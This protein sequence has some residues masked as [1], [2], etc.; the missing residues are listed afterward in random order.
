MKWGGGGKSE[1]WVGYPTLPYLT[2][3]SSSGLFNCSR[4]E[5]CLCVCG[6]GV[7]V[8]IGWG[9]LPWGMGR[10]IPTLPYPTLPY[11]T[12]PYPTLPYPTLPYPTLPY[13]T[14]PYPYPYPY[15]TLPYPTLPY[16]TLPYHSLPYPTLPYPTLPYP[17]LP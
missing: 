17:T 14:L 9:T 5:M 13:P 2:P 7:R 3:R 16:P 11:P 15:P 12:L 8:N 4:N 1:Q 10:S 6:G